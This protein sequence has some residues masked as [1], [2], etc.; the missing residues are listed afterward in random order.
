MTKRS[1]QKVQARRSSL[2]TF[3]KVVNYNHMMPTRYTLDLDLKPVIAADAVEAGTKKVEAR[4]V[5]LVVCCFFVCCLCAAARAK[6]E[7]GRAPLFFLERDACRQVTSISWRAGAK[8]CR[9]GCT[10]RR[11][12]CV[13]AG[14]GGGGGGNA[15]VRKPC[16]QHTPLLTHT[17]QPQKNT[18]N[19]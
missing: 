1:S 13:C 16:V 4:K 15:A 11:R 19:A 8:H 6:R 14:G 17:T 3:I 5:R 12:P 2:K 18:K 10:A 9:S 7:R